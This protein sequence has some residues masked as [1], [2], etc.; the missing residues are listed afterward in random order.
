MKHL[1]TKHVASDELR[2]ASSDSQDAA[3]ARLSFP[4]AT[5][6]SQLVTSRAGISLLEVLI[7]MFVMLFGLMGVAAIFPVGNHYAGKGDEFDRGASLAGSAFAELR[8][9]GL[10]RPELWLYADVP[11]GGTVTGDSR[12]IEPAFIGANPNPGAG[13]FNMTTVVNAGHAFVIDPIGAAETLPADPGGDFFPFNAN[14]GLEP[15]GAPW[16]SPAPFGLAGT[17]WPIRRVTFSPFPG[18]T[19]MGPRVA[20]AIFRLRDD[21]SVAMPEENDRPG[22]LRWSAVDQQPDGTQNN[23]PKYEADD[24]RHARSYTGSYSWLATVVPVNND[25]LDG[26]QPSDPRHSSYLY[27][28]SVAVFHRREEV[29]SAESERMLSAQLGLGG[30]LVLY[31]DNSISRGALDSINAASQ[32]IRP[33]QWIALAGVHP[34]TGKFLLRWYRLLSFDSETGNVRR[35]DTNREP[36]GRRAMIDGPEWPMIEINNVT[37]PALNLRA[38]L[39]PNVIGVATQTVKLE[40]D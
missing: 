9:R 6:N 31:F 11:A 29:P 12:V 20:E 7:A 36:Y 39:L 38:I 16:D 10:M 2:V 25:A 24:T 33:G 19:K 5:R 4:L 28:V 17:T 37:Q 3:G 8:S 26:L 14:G 15:T 30:D 22:I 35:S 13:T 18:G 40:T 27:E 21:V 1:S 32:D 23:T 34:T